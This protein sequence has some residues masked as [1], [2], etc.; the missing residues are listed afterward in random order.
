[1]GISAIPTDNP[2]FLGMEGMHGHYAS[3]LAMHNSGCIIALGARF[4]DRGTGK[5]SKFA[6]NTKI[7]HIDV[8][9]SELSKTTNDVVGLARRYKE[10]AAKAASAHKR[11]QKTRSG[12]RK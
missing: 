3:S 2:R 12:R 1:M 4:N 6:V 11:G 8:D 7:I 5:R 9:G 10:D